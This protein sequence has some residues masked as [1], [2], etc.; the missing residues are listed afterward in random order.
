M[1]LWD[2]LDDILDKNLTAWFDSK[3]KAASKKKGSRKYMMRTPIACTAKQA[4]QQMGFNPDAK[5]SFLDRQVGGAFGAIPRLA[6]GY[7]YPT[8]PLHPEYNDMA[9]AGR[10]AWWSA[11]MTMALG[12]Q[13]AKEIADSHEIGGSNPPS[14]RWMDLYNNQIGR[15]I[16][17]ELRRQGKSILDIP[18]TVRKALGN[19]RLAIR[20]IQD[21][22]GN[23]G[24]FFN[25]NLRK[26]CRP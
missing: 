2:D 1:A 6:S 21:N 24:D 14:E 9:D 19:D 25:N 18:N 3:E 17:T 16:G 11:G 7:I 15:Q 26:R 22:G 20:P 10:H 13:K 8:D 4:E 12:P 23:G 5:A